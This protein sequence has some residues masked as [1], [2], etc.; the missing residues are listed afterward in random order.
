[1]FSSLVLF[2]QDNKVKS[3]VDVLTTFS[4]MGITTE[5]QSGL[6]INKE[7]K[8]LAGF[9]T[10]F[11]YSNSNHLNLG[12]SLGY[13][14]L[15]KSEKHPRI[16][17]GFGPEVK[18]YFAPNFSHLEAFL[19]GVLQVEMYKGFSFFTKSGVGI[20]SVFTKATTTQLNGNLT[21][22]FGYAF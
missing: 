5:I 18:H 22:G 6:I 20:R 15:N 8:I 7:H 1:M 3:F 2:S 19:Q 17:F 11:S 21:I 9:G 4:G 13:L 14:W 10:N 12:Y 16:T